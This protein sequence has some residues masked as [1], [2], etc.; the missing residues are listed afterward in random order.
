MCLETV[1]GDGAVTK[2][3]VLLPHAGPANA[4]TPA[5]VNATAATIDS[6]LPFVM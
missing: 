4:K 6:V 1:S 2:I 3:R 5:A